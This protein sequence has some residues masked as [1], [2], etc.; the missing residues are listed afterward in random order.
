MAFMTTVAAQTKYETVPSEKFT[1]I[2][3]DS[4]TGPVIGKSTATLTIRVLRLTLQGENII[5]HSAGDG[6]FTLVH[7]DGTVFSG[8]FIKTPTGDFRLDE[9]LYPENF[10]L[11]RADIAKREPTI[12]A[13]IPPREAKPTAHLYASVGYAATAS[14]IRKLL[15]GLMSAN[16]GGNYDLSILGLKQSWYKP[17]VFAEA[18]FHY[19]NNNPYLLLGGSL[20]VGPEWRYSFAARH[21]MFL[22]AG[23][24][25]NYLRVRD[26]LIDQA[27]IGFYAQSK[28][29][30]AFA[31]KG[32][33]I[34]CALTT[35]YMHDPIAPL[36]A[37][38]AQIGVAHAWGDKN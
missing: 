30:Y 5:S 1:C 13:E 8:K 26:N 27:H 16:F 38:G 28:V 3:G 36:T 6:G 12:L 10:D 32:W 31:F 22:Q 7:K 24:G 2:N 35:I 19:A 18:A 23:A 21:T 34:F 20:V 37:I 15:P 11:L 14:Q 29:G 25:M 9:P 33:I 17:W 4:F